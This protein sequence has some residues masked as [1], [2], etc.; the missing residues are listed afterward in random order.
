M[1]RLL[2]ALHTQ[3]HWTQALLT[4]NNYEGLLHLVLDKVG[5][6]GRGGQDGAG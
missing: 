3:L 4:A 1:P 5:W 2:T 6:K